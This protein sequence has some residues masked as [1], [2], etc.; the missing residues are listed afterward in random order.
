[1]L[2]AAHLEQGAGER[3]HESVVN[4]L[5]AAAPDQG[6]LHPVL[7]SWGGRHAG[8]RGAAPRKP[9]LASLKEFAFLSLHRAIGSLVKAVPEVPTPDLV[10]DQTTAWRLMEARRIYLGRRRSWVASRVVG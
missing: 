3:R 5:K 6:Q 10:G 2:L 7:G 8:C 9:A 4:E 1:M